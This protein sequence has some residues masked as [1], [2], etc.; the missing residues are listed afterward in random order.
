MAQHKLMMNYILVSGKASYGLLLA[1]PVS[2][3][4]LEVWPFGRLNLCN[5]LRRSKELMPKLQSKFFF[6]LL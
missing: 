5:I 3:L 6:M 1:S 4:L 2:H